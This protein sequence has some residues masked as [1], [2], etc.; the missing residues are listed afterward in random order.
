MPV[1]NL[2]KRTATRLGGSIWERSR[3]RELGGYA[4]VLRWN[5]KEDTQLP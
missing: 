3:Q 5:E 4:D 1:K 2:S